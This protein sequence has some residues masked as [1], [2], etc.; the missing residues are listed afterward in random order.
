[1]LI[2]LQ[3]MHSKGIFHMDIKLE[4]VIIDAEGFIKLTDFGM[5]FWQ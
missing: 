4:N 1:M 2:A 3:A 5:S